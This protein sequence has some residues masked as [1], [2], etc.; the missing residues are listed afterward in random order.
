MNVD[1]ICGSD[2]TVP[3]FSDTSAPQPL[4]SV[5]SMLLSCQVVEKQLCVDLKGP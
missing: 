5:V 2:V 3:A 4:C 1:I